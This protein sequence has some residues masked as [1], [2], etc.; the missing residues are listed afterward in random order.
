IVTNSSLQFLMKQSTSSVDKLAEVFYLSSG[1]RGLL[2]SSNVG[3]GLFFAGSAHV[4]L[5]VVASPEE[6][7]LITTNPRELAAMDEDLAKQQK[8]AQML[9]DQTPG[10]L[11]E[12]G[13]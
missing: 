2:V 3:E 8:I 7:K 9:E 6:H 12:T 10:S 5:Q 4:A 1:E 13:A 11:S